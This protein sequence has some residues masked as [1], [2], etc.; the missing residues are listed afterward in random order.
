[1]A[2]KDAMRQADPILMEPVM[3]VEVV[4][5]EEY[6]GDVIGDLSA[7]RGKVEGMGARANARV[8]KALVPLAEMFGYVNDL[9]SKTSGRASYTMKFDRYEEVSRD[10]ADK[11]LRR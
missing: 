6:M 8:V 4:M 10:V 5:P 1:M 3:S 11:L 7:R 9:R 2:F